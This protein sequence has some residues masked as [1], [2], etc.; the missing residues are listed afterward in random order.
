[1]VKILKNEC[2]FD[3]FMLVKIYE[4]KIK[5]NSFMISFFDQ[6]IFISIDPM[7]NLS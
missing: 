4:K 5:Y 7:C 6:Y 2:F 1:M 3:A